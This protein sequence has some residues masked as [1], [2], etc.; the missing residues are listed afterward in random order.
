MMH[1]L[2][3]LLLCANL[4]FSLA[5]PFETSAQKLPKRQYAPEDNSDPY[6]GRHKWIP[7]SQINGASRTS[8]PFLNTAANHAFL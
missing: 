1:V 2:V 6:S 7:A 8:C 3:P 4:P 5:A